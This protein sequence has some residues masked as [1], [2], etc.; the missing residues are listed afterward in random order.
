MFCT[1]DI[2]KGVQIEV[3]SKRI[4]THPFLVAKTCQIKMKTKFALW[5]SGP[6]SCYGRIWWIL[7]LE[8]EGKLNAY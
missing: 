5:Q 6:Y 7:Y 8:V 1:N 3:S 4:Y 2:F